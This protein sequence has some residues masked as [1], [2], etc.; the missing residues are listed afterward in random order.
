MKLEKDKTYENIEYGV[1]FSGR[2]IVF[3]VRNTETE[4]TEV[5][6]YNCAREPLVGIDPYD[7]REVE[8]LIEKNTLSL[9]C[10]GKDCDTCR[11]EKLIAKGYRKVPDGSV[12]LTK[13]EYYDLKNKVKWAKELGISADK[14]R[15]EKEMEI[16]K[17]LNGFRFVM[18]DEGYEVASWTCGED[19]VKQFAKEIGV[20]V[21]E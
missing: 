10:R 13:E 18:Y 8:K 3:C 2:E 12:V 20:E 19:E 4:E 21:E 5:G 14:I 17:K 15:K 6:I 16:L 9:R 7:E 1:S 11:L